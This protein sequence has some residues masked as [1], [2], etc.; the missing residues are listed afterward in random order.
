M[1]TTPTTHN[2]VDEILK[3]TELGTFIA[4]NKGAI[5]GLVVAIIIGVFAWGGYTNFKS[6]KNDELGAIVFN[7]Q[8]TSYK[9][10][11]EKKMTTVEFLKGY[12]AMASGVQ[13]FDGLVPFAIIAS[14]EI[15]NQNDLESSLAVLESVSNF[16]N[17][18]MLYFVHSRMAVLNEDLGKTDKAIESL[19][20]IV[21]A[22]IKV[23]ES[24]TY[25][26]LGRLYLKKGNAEK[27]KSNFQFVVDSMGQAEFVKLAKLYLSEME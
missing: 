13:G 15:K 23:M 22:N 19:E 25:L 16:N 10:L 11:V 21:K 8:Q 4:N 26:D 2:P 5:I 20:K 7:F 12:Q 1:S 18:Y 27:A 24:K 3:E 14:D 17:P 9:N 6:N